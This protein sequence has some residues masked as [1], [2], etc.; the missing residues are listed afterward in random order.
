MARELEIDQKE[1]EEQRALARPN[2]GARSLLKK[3]K[4]NSRL[5]AAS[6]TALLHPA[7]AVSSKR[8]GS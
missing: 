5:V 8:P 4:N 2:G 6:E 3:N 7:S 1:Q